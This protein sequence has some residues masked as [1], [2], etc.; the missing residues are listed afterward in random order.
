MQTQLEHKAFLLLLAIVSVAFVWLLLP[1]YGAVFWAVILAIVF[2]PLQRNFEYRFGL[3]SNLAV[4]PERA[5]LH[6]DRDHPDDAHRRGA[7]PRGNRARGPGAE[8]PHRPLEKPF[9]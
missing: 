6:R 1:F 9:W 7:G 4:F 5:R 8:R 2:Q 3:R